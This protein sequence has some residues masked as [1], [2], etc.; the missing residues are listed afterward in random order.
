[1]STLRASR[2]VSAVAILALVVG[3][4]DGF[5]PRAPL[6]RH[7]V[8]APPSTDASF[9]KLRDRVLDDLLAASPDLARARG[10]HDYDGKVAPLSNEAF[11]AR[12]RWIQ[13]F[14]GRVSPTAL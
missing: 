6:T 2:L 11:A 3:C 8:G 13:P 14:R 10:L 9:A 4:P 1:M 5:A 7:R 12:S